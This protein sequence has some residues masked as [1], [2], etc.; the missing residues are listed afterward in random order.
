MRLRGLKKDIFSQKWTR[1]CT[2][3]D[4]TSFEYTKVVATSFKCARAAAQPD[5][6]A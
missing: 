6:E 3:D 1:L 4:T 5:V 2:E